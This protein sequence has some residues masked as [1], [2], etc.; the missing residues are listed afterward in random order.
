MALAPLAESVFLTTQTANT[1]LQRHRRYN[2]GA[3]E[4][5]LKGNLERECIE[6]KCDLEEAREID[7]P[8][9]VL[10]RVSQQGQRRLPGGQWG[11]A[12]K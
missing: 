11:A 3:F 12:R 1:I 4:E 5:L 8:L 7:H 9:H 10:C 6:E 2:T